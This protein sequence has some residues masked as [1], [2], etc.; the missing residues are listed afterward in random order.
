MSH[1]HYLIKTSSHYAEAYSG[2]FQNFCERQF[3]V[4]VGSELNLTFLSSGKR[5]FLFEKDKSPI[6]FLN[7]CVRASIYFKEFSIVW[8]CGLLKKLIIKKCDGLRKLAARR[9]LA[10]GRLHTNE[11]SEKVFK[12]SCDFG[13][14]GDFYFSP[15]FVILA[16]S[17][18]PVGRPCLH[19]KLR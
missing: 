11:E 16:V 4:D 13:R 5:I 18:P 8:R 6:A 2:N 17:L 14:V 12:F 19:C 10:F 7:S 9:K 1:S 3:R 15:N